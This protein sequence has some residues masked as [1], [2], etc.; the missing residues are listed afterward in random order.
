[1]YQYHPAMYKP[2][3]AQ[4]FRN[5]LALT[6]LVLCLW[7]PQASRGQQ[8]AITVQLFLSESLGQTTIADILRTLPEDRSVTVMVRGLLP[9]D[10]PLNRTIRY[11]QT[12]MDQSGTSHGVQIDPVAF[13]DAGITQ[14]PTLLL[15]EDNKSLLKVVGVTSREWLLRGAAINNLPVPEQLPHPISLT[16]GGE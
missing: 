8:S 11:W 5:N 9:G 1:M 12:I 2:N 6:C 14:V 13:S 16:Q 7:M 10:K 15:S 3:A 4:I